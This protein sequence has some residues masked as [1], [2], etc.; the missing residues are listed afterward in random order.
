M[1]SNVTTAWGA[2][3]TARWFALWR[4]WR[5]ARPISILKKNQ[6]KSPSVR[7]TV[8]ASIGNLRTSPLHCPGT[9][10][11]AHDHRVHISL[12]QNLPCRKCLRLQVQRNRNSLSMLAMPPASSARGDSF[13][14]SKKESPPKKKTSTVRI[15]YC[16][17]KKMSWRKENRTFRQRFVIRSWRISP[18]I[19]FN[20]IKTSCLTTPSLFGLRFPPKRMLRRGGERQRD[21]SGLCPAKTAEF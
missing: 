10:Q 5:K 17:R 7:R 11:S 3:P 20:V 2:P 8:R 9:N 4:L 21:Q 15:W 16:N 19:L 12:H 18:T 6:T 13:M 1:T 14:I